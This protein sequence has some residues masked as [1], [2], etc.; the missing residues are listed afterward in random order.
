MAVLLARTAD[1]LYWGARYIERAED[2]ARVVRAYHELVVD[3]PS[4]ELLPWAPLVAL[5]GSADDVPVREDDPAGERAVLELVLGDLDNESSIRSSVRAARENL[6]T[7]RE[8]MPREAWQ[9]VNEL[10]QYV[11][12]TAS[13][14]VER[15]LRD[16]FLLRVVQISRR[17]D[18]ILESTMSRGRSYRMLRLGRLIERADMTTRV[19][20]VA[21]ASLIAAE[22]HGEELVAEQVRW[23]SVLRSVSA[24]QM[25]QRSDR[26]PIDGLNVV[27]FLLFHSRF[28]RSVLGCLDEIRAVV[29]TLPRPDAANRALDDAVAV[30]R[31]ADPHHVDGEKLDRS[32][33]RVQVAIA[34]LHE[35][36]QDAYVRHAL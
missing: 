5:H 12:A 33:D 2:T 28:P 29:D 13:A 25:Y 30:L 7:T 3:Y 24:L 19:V 6:R 10:S 22:E 16:R 18:G 32:M 26:G 9:A 20:G 17:L 36:M 4:S 14:A 8:V 31:S 27:R 35:A 1:R 15:Q 11:D 21:A 23:M 34:A